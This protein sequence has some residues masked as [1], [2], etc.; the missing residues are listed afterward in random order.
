MP[1]AVVH[2]HLSV[3]SG[4]LTRAVDVGGEVAALAIGAV[5]RAARASWL[6]QRALMQA[7]R[8]EVAREEP[9]RETATRQE[10]ARE[11]AAAHEVRVARQKAQAA[12]STMSLPRVRAGPNLEGST[13]NAHEEETGLDSLEAAEL[14]KCSRTLLVSAEASESTKEAEAMA[15]ADEMLAA[16]AAATLEAAEVAATSRMRSTTATMHLEPVQ[17]PEACTLAA[18]LAA[19]S[20]QIEHVSHGDEWIRSHLS[21]V[22]RRT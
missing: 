7:V 15:A 14:Y 16:R 17:R 8:E 9:L 11:E 20:M 21:F 1:A 19:M 3:V 12:T 4:D 22:M 6:E 5:A 13:L 2:A 18:A 10:A